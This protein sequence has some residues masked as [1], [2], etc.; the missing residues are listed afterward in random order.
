MHH[1]TPDTRSELGWQ[2]QQQSMVSVML[3]F[4][5][6]AGGRVAHAAD[7]FVTSTTASLSVTISVTIVHVKQTQQS[8]HTLATHSYIDFKIIQVGKERNKEGARRK[9][10]VRFWS[11]VSD[12]DT[13]R[14]YGTHFPKIKLTWGAA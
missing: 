11:R 14:E 13:G 6:W 10:I 1:G 7:T 2:R 3:P 12:T 9:E 4:R 5:S 8:I